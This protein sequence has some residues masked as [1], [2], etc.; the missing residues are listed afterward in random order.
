M[1]DASYH[2]FG[3]GLGTQDLHYI[4]WTQKSVHDQHDQIV[5]DLQHGN[6][7]DIAHWVENARQHGDINV[8]EIESA[9]SMEEAKNSVAFLR[10]YFHSLGLDVISDS[11]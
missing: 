9:R 4:G 1:A 2:V 10:R 5:S 11:A 6:N 3:L 8:F 7:N